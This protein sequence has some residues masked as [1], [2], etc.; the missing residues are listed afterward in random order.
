MLI[1][2]EG[3]GSPTLGFPWRRLFGISMASVAWNFLPMVGGGVTDNTIASKIATGR[4][5]IENKHIH[6]YTAL[7]SEIRP[8]RHTC[9]C[10]IHG[11]DVTICCK[12]RKVIQ[13]IPDL[14]RND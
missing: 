11:S 13:N 3:G 5:T 14:N 1:N 12:S 8:Y 9:L 2:K 4:Y 6:I 7:K 10:H